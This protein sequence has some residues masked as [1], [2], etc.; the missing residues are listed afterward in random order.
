[1]GIVGGPGDLG[2]VRELVLKSVDIHNGDL[3]YLL[4]VS[5]EHEL[6][7]VLIR[8]TSVRLLEFDGD[9]LGDMKS[10]QPLEGGLRTRPARWAVVQT[11]GVH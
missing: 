4:G 2:D 1:V 7:Y 10:L 5:P 8:A 6:G 9:I 3:V 11:T